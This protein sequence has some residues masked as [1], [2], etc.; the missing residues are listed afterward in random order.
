M[1]PVLFLFLFC[2]TL[3]TA[4]QTSYSPAD[5]VIFARYLK[6]I[7]P[8][9]ELPINQLIIETAKFLSG[10]PYVAATLEKEPEQLVVNLHEFDCFT[11]TENC[12]ALALTA[13]EAQPS[14]DSFC[15]HL[16]QIRYQEG[17]INGYTSRL[18]YTTHWIIE[19]EKQ[20]R[21]KNITQA[22]GGI[23]LPLQLFFMSANP[24]KYKQLKNEPE[25]V[26]SMREK[27]QEI[28][29]HAHFYIPK[30]EIN[31]LSNKIQDGDIVCFTTSIKGLDVTHVGFAYWQNKQLTF[32][33]ASSTA[34]KV[35]IN[36]VSLYNYCMASKSNTGLLLVRVK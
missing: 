33:H 14:F 16:Q 10:A 30:E 12:L 17:K 25:L 32:I 9:K 1:K 11:L 34:G 4:T 23:P 22:A 19:N 18:H 13:K 28:N 6:A 24:D 21:L 29:K 2:L 7:E 3:H 31:T 20:G 8:A 26:A 5:E 15:K 35:I 27:E 36:P